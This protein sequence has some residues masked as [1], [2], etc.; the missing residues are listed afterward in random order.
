MS[1]SE[2]G[3]AAVPTTP[4]PLWAGPSDRLRYVLRYAI[5]APSR[6][7]AQ[8]WL[9]EIEGDEARLYADHRRALPVADPQGREMFMSCGAALFNLRV[10][11]SHF[12]HATSVEVLASAGRRDGL[13]ARL[14][15]EERRASTPDMDELFRAIPVRRT[16]RLPLDSREPPAGLVTALLREARTEGALLRTVED[17][18]RC[19]VAELV[20]EGSRIQW[21]T[22]RFCAEL[23]AWSRPNGTRSLDGMPGY[24]H[25]MSNAASYLQRLR[26]RFANPGL[27]EADRD[28]RRALSTRALVALSTRGDTAADWLAAGEALQRVLL[29][30][31]AAGLYASYF[32]QPIELSDLRTRLR[33][34]L[35]ETGHP[36][37][38]FR[39]GYGLEVRATPRRPV[40][41][42]LRSVA[43]APPLRAEA[44]VLRVPLAGGAVAA[45]P[46]RPPR[47]APHRAGAR[48]AGAVAGQLPG[49]VGG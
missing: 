13:A 23:A 21:R 12:G 39:L 27:V 6:H 45:A 41:A 28:R 2:L 20:A 47:P 9:F 25:G 34:T 17:N 33:Q 10:A 30:A 4:F 46:G 38:M 24:A 5:L 42:V 37:L 11:A 35:G 15:L 19:A 18:E 8:P 14:R 3:T 32:N 16:N 36:Q 48:S 22:P 26:M 40:G 29:R 31:T 1:T 7:N 44:L 49:D 43:D